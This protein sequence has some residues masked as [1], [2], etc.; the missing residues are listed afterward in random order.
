[1]TTGS[2]SIC[3]Q[4]NVLLNLNYYNIAHRRSALLSFI[5]ILFASLALYFKP[6]EEISSI[7]KN[8]RGIFPVIVIGGATSEYYDK[9]S[10][11]TA[12][13]AHVALWTAEIWRKHIE[14]EPLIIFVNCTLECDNARRYLK[15]QEFKVIEINNLPK[16]TCVDFKSGTVV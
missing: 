14:V 16:R 1:M 11:T 3:T 7:T 8:L 9:K 2:K 6:K 15:E 5:L 4:I 12:H 13:Y 10:D